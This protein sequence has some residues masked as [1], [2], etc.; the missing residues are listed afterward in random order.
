M[1]ITHW[2]QGNKQKNTFVPSQKE[3]NWTPHEC[4]LSLFI[5]C[6]NFYFQTV[7]HHFWPGQMVAAQTVGHSVIRI[8]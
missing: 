2:E 7:C 1:M 5:G 3:K 8:N 6:M 4:M